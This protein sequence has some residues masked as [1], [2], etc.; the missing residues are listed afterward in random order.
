MAQNFLFDTAWLDPV[1]IGEEGIVFGRDNAFGIGTLIVL[2]CPFTNR[3]LMGRKSF[4]EGFEGSNQFT[5]PGGMLRSEANLDFKTCLGTTLQERVLA[6]T[7]VS[8][9]SIESLVP[10][11]EWP[12]VVGRYTIRGTQ[13]VSAA[14]LPFYGESKTELPTWTTDPTVYAMGWYDP[15]EVMHEITQTNA[16]ILAQAFWAEYSTTQQEEILPILAPH[17]EAVI[18]NAEQLGAD[19]P[20][21][22]WSV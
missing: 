4:R 14:I 21:A 17:F 3:V 15:L 11:D 16:L 18:K 5:L 2:R 6:E 19:L 22:P 8:I 12:P 1:S 7:G 13:L 20:F 10:L 9:Q